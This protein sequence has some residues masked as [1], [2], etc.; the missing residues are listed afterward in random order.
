MVA[1][2]ENGL[3]VDFGHFFPLA[4]FVYGDNNVDNN[5]DN[6][7]NKDTIGPGKQTHAIRNTKKRNE[8]KSS[9]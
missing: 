2:F 5:N 3:W 1:V 6:D 4:K 7:K 8:K 9:Q